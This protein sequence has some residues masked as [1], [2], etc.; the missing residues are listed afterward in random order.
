MSIKE[1]R[2]SLREDP[3]LKRFSS[4]YK[5]VRGSMNMERIE[6]EVRFLHTNRS[7]RSLTAAK[8]SPT[9]L[10]RANVE[11]LSARSRLTEIKLM[12]YRTSEL[13]SIS[14]DRARSYV[15]TEY[16]DEV[17]EVSGRTKS[18]KDTALNTLFEGPISFLREVES[19]SDQI[20][21]IIKDIDQSSFNLR[22][23][24]DLLAIQLDRRE[25]SL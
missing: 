17:L 22:R 4:V 24:Q 1:L 25:H 16:R 2:D 19:L 5:T 15:R 3:N 6:Q 7:A 18:E 13:L 23:L 9:V 20:D 11:D 12:C 8:I 21:M 10:S 14:L